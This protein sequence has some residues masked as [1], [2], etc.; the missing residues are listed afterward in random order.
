MEEGKTTNSENQG[1]EGA[2]QLME[3]DE[4]QQEGFPQEERGDETEEKGLMEDVRI[5]PIPVHPDSSCSNNTHTHNLT[6]NNRV[7][8]S[9]A[10]LSF[11]VNG[12][13]VSLQPGVSV[14]VRV[15]LCL[16]VFVCLYVF[17][18]L[19]VFVCLF[20]FVHLCLCVSVFVC[21]C[22]SLSVCVRLCLCLS[23]FVCVC[24]SLSV[25]VRLCPPGGTAE[26]K[27]CS[28]PRGSAS[29][30]TTV[31]MSSPLKVQEPA[32]AQ[33]NTSSLQAPLAGSDPT[34]VITGVV[35][36][37]AAQ[38]VLKDHSKSRTPLTEKK[39]QPGVSTPNVT[40]NPP[41][42]KPTSSNQT[43]TP[44]TPRAVQ[45]KGQLGPAPPDCPVCRSQFKFI[46]KLRGFMCL[47]CPAI[48]LSLE[49]VRKKKQQKR[50]RLKRSRDMIRVYR[51][52]QTFR[53][54]GAQT[55]PGPGPFAVVSPP[56]RTFRVSEDKLESLQTPQGKLVILVEDFYYGSAPGRHCT[57][58][59]TDDGNHGPYDCIRCQRTLHNNIELMN[60]AKLHITSQQ[61]RRRVSS[62][63]HC[64]RRFTSLFSLQRH[65]QAVH[66]PCEYRAQCK[67]CEVTFMSEV[68]FLDHMKTNHKPGEMP[69][70]CQ[71]C[72][73]RSSFYS[74]IWSH[75]ERAH[76]N[77]KHLLCPF[78]LR[79]MSHNTC[80]Q[81]HVNRHQ[82]KMAFSC[83]QCRLHFLHPK[84]LSQHKLIHH[85]THIRP[86]QLTGLRPGTKVTV[87]TFSVGGRSEMEEGQRD[88]SP[89]KVVN[90]DT[91][92]SRQEASKR[93]LVENL[94]GLLSSLSQDSGLDGGV[95]RTSSVCVECLSSVQDFQTHFPSLVCCPLCSFVTCCCT[96]YANHMISYHAACG[97]TPQYA[98]IFVSQPRLSE[99]LQCVTCSFSIDRGDIMANH[100]TER[101]QHCCV[102]LHENVPSPL[103]EPPA[104][105]QPSDKLLAPLED[106]FEELCEN[107]DGHVRLLS[108]KSEPEDRD[109]QDQE[110]QQVLEHQQNQDSEDEKPPRWE[111][112]TDKDNEGVLGDQVLTHEDGQVLVSQQ[113]GPD[114][115][116]SGRFLFFHLIDE[117]GQSH[118][119]Y[120]SI[121]PTPP[122]APTVNQVRSRGTRRGRL[123]RG[124]TKSQ[125]APPT[126]RGGGAQDSTSQ[127]RLT[128]I[129]QHIESFHPTAGHYGRT[130][131]Q[132]Q[133][134]L[135][136]DVS[137]R[138]MF[139]DFAANHRTSFK[140]Y[141]KA[142]ESCGV[143]FSRPGEEPCELCLRHQ[144]H[145]SVRHRDQDWV[146]HLQDPPPD[147]ITCRMWEEHREKAE[148]ATRDY[149][150]DARKQQ[151]GELSIRR[152]DLQRV[153]L[154]PRMPGVKPALL[155]KRLFVFHETFATVGQR[156]G[157]EKKSI[158]VIW[159]EGMA[160]RKAV[161]VASA[162]VV[163]LQRERDVAHVVLWVDGCTVQNRNW[164][165][166][167]T[168]VMAVNQPWS[169]T[170]DVT[171]KYFEPGHTFMR[172]ECF[173]QRL[174]HEM[175][176]QPGGRVLDF[177]DFKRVVAAA[178]WGEVDVVELQNE[179]IRAWKEGN[180]RRKLT[181][182]PPLPELAQVQVRR[183][184]RLL[185]VKLSHNQEDFTP[186]DF[187]RNRTRLSVPELLRPADRGVGRKKKAEILRKL[188][189]LLPERSRMFWEG[190]TESAEEE[191]EEDNYDEEEEA[192]EED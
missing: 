44:H 151:S 106:E 19:S 101:P 167:T 20:V 82:C 36:G 127:V 16:S 24:P 185:W 139:E 176:R 38:R 170:E 105:D 22:P 12:R 116:G 180:S 126:K 57:N 184:S 83:G 18:C 125:V 171:L 165:L 134:F 155:T 42:I 14:F 8:G 28:H 49:K 124:G 32:E 95:S 41:Q 175:E 164:C 140:R 162:Y 118:D 50:S 67:I 138:L 153:I 188:C 39:N 94:G 69:Y 136:S 182:T 98:N 89:S 59:Q 115:D 161:E 122:V 131:A 74:D 3:W 31:Q 25:F 152:V 142:L 112:F 177:Q 64:L 2:E 130:Q 166:L 114:F 40:S 27:I 189:P 71:V 86:A 117:R 33:T 51:D 154:L 159:H 7:K 78:C 123:S 109:Y 87:R 88:T 92:P 58:N 104:D 45:E 76:S 156:R 128:Q 99:K 110:N 133:R 6:H 121:V 53:H 37:E 111:Q 79:V 75:F 73:F 144:H 96:A 34:L 62:C 157:S 145:M 100:L 81:Q 129:H 1:G 174:E 35:S 46:L 15:C 68:D 158:S 47:C 97:T 54:A 26:L 183:G 187:L 93:K 186:V 52:P 149:K 102:M 107:S 103:D 168:L 119:I 56:L 192:E 143:S 163:A 29:G 84:E 173:H 11:K 21:V 148:K 70:T 63:P 10:P 120:D 23:V 30:F 179:D 48:A 66:S 169:C 141:Q 146:Q 132:D 4:E 108:P 178:Q 172:T 60:H 147:C 5:V 55:R 77:S 65:L 61:D 150:R 181:N 190:L 17:V 137:L 85:C 160:L 72:D 43:R 135:P 90:F 91:S 191:E 9:G 80:Y 13:L 113:Q